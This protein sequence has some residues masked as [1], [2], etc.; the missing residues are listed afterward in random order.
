MN[1]SKHT[2]TIM[3]GGRN[4]RQNYSLAKRIGVETKI[5]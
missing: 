2:K 5:N 3:D 1:T 4:D